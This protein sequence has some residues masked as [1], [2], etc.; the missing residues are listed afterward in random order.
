MAST[1]AVAGVLVHM[2]AYHEPA[3]APE[4]DYPASSSR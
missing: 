2:E 3:T 1:P 4:R